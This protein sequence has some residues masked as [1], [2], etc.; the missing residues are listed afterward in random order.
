MDLSQNVC[1]NNSD[2]AGICRV[3][4]NSGGCAKCT[5]GYDRQERTCVECNETCGS[6]LNGDSCLTCAKVS[7]MTVTGECKGKNETAACSG[8]IDSVD[9][10]VACDAGHYLRDKECHS[11]GDAFDV[12]FVR[13]DAVSVV[14]RRVC[15]EGRRMR[16]RLGHRAL[17]GG[18]RITVHGVH[19]PAPPNA[20]RGGCDARAVWLVILVAV[21]MTLFVAVL[22]AAC[23]VAAI[24]LGMKEHKQQDHE[25]TACVLAMSRSNVAFAP[26][27]GTRA[28]SQARTR[29][30]L[31]TARSPSVPRRRRCC[32]L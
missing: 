7:F 27:R 11:C 9:G 5:T 17:H 30:S 18:V 1:M 16:C 8:E 21:A 26:L 25:G 22:V 12:C 19:V 6:C 15:P 13:R 31:G 4:F 23:V 29:V 2:L 24:D 20:R 10:C 28:S 32:A 3:F 14:C